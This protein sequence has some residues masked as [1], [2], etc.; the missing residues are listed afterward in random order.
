MGPRQWAVG[1]RT[2]RATD[3]HKQRQIERDKERQIKRPRLAA[4]ERK[5]KE[6]E[7]I[8]TFLL[9]YFETSFLN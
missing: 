5:G 6:K 8:D 2:D 7:L 4:G 3:R 9:L 1:I